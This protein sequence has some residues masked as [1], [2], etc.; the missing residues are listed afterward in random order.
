M[1]EAGV[2]ALDPLRL[3]RLEAYLVG[4]DEGCR[5]R[6]AQVADVARVAGVPVPP[7]LDELG[8]VAA[9]CRGAADEIRWRRALLDGLPPLPPP[10][11]VFASRSAA[12]DRAEALVERFEGALYERP[13]RPELLRRLLAEAAR[14]V[15]SP[16]F[17]AALVEGLGPGR[18]ARLAELSAELGLAGP[19]LAGSGGAG[20][21]PV[22]PPPVDEGAPSGVTLADVRELIVVAVGSDHPLL[23]WIDDLPPIVADAIAASDEMAGIVGNAVQAVRAMRGSSVAAAALGP[24]RVGTLVLDGLDATRDPSD[25]ELWNLASS[26]LSTIAPHTGPAAPFVFFG[27]ALSAAIGWMAATAKMSPS[28]RDDF[29]RRFDPDTGES[30]YPSGSAH[31]PWVDGAGVPL[32]PRY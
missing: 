29:E 3:V 16:T 19:S 13:P 9:W 22:L 24:F 27:A 2:V 17:L 5:R 8:L 10:P 21:A 32:D 12:T 25:V 7:A 31:S 30:T 6:A 23:D 1:A 15:E 28:Q 4:L 18:V 11:F 14:G 26:L 20:T